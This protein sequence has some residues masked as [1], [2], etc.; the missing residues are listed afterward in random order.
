MNKRKLTVKQVIQELNDLGCPAHDHPEN[1]GRVSWR[2]ICKG[3]YG[4]WLY[5]HD[6]TAFYCAK[7]D[8]EQY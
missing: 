3:T 2:T 4:A 1:G 8:L 6:K 5:R 7:N